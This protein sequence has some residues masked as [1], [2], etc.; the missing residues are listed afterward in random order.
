MIIKDTLSTLSKDLLKI[1]NK[2]DMIYNDK[3][4]NV[5]NTDMYKNILL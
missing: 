4:N 1:N 5:I 2:L 3:L